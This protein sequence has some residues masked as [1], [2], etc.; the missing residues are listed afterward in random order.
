MPVSNRYLLLLRPTSSDYVGVNFPHFSFLFSI[1]IIT[2]F[3]LFSWYQWVLGGFQ[4][5]NE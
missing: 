2:T 1:I 5:M 4:S 3:S